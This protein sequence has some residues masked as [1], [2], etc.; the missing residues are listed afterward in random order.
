M[1]LHRIVLNLRSG[2]AA[3]GVASASLPATAETF[4]C[5][6]AF[7]HQAMQFSPTADGWISAPGD[8][9]PLYSAEVFDG[10]PEQRA[11]LQPRASTRNTSSW[12][13]EGAYP[14]GI[15]LQCTYA[16]G[17]LVLSRTLPKV[18]AVCIA[19][20]PKMSK[21]RPLSVSFDCH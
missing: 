3:L 9:A 21:G 13:F 20:Y 4:D 17:A 19:S 16:G 8:P 15:W 10:P 2:I 12:A 1:T 11:S 18:P 6:P 5:P 14:Q 7:P